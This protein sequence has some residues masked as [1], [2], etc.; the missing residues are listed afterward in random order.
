MVLT[1]VRNS[2]NQRISGFLPLVRNSVALG[3]L[4]SFIVGNSKVWKLGDS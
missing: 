1:M 3:F 2:L 4:T